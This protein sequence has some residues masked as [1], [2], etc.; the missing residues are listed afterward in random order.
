MATTNGTAALIT[1]LNALG[2]EP[3]DEVIVP[4]YTFIATVNAVLRHYALPVF[5]DTDPETSRSTPARSRRPSPIAPRRSCRCISAARLP[6]WTPS[7]R[8]PET[9][10]AG[11]RGCLPGPPGRVART[12]SGTSGTPGASASRLKEPELA[13]KAAP[14]CPTTAS[15]PRSCFAFHNNGRG[16]E[17]R[18]LPLQLRVHRRANLRMTEF[19]AALLL[20]QMTRLEEQARTAH[21]ER[22]NT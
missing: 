9:Q 5:V 3:G 1:S 12:G 22:A 15:W 8:S 10:P 18:R 19:Q 17:G 4:P 7:S 6:T 16:A 14:S 21:R 20:A 2:I 11:D 13:A